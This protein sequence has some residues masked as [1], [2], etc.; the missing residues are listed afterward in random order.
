[1]PPIRPTRRQRDRAPRVNRTR[2][3]SVRSK[4]TPRTVPNTAEGAGAK[5]QA[6]A[7]GL[8]SFF[9]PLQTFGQAQQRQALDAIEQENRKLAIEA[10]NQALRNPQKAAEAIRQG[11]LDQFAPNA[12]ALT[13]RAFV[14]TFKIS[15][16]KALANET[17][18][19]EW[20]DRLR[21]L[22]F[23]TGDPRETRNEILDEALDEKS[24]PIF[25]AQFR[26]TFQ[27]T[28]EK[29]IQNWR[30]S[31]AAFQQAQALDRRLDVMRQE[32]QRGKQFTSRAF[33]DLIADSMNSATTAENK[34][35]NRK[36][37][38]YQIMFNSLKS[39]NNS[40][41][42]AIH[43][44]DP[45]HDGLSLADRF[46]EEFK[47]AQKTAISDIGQVRSVEQQR[48]Y[49]EIEDKLRQIETNGVATVQTEDGPVEM[50]IN[51]VTRELYRSR[52]KYGWSN[53]WS[54]LADEAASLYGATATARDLAQKAQDCVATGTCPY[55]DPT[56]MNDHGSAIVD[57]VT[58]DKEPT[59]AAAAVA[60]LATRYGGLGNDVNRRFSH[61][62][63]NTGDPEK[64]TGTFRQLEAIVAADNGKLDTVEGMLKSD[65]AKNKFRFLHHMTNARGMNP[66]DAAL[67]YEE[68]EEAVIKPENLGTYV[69]KREDQQSLISDTVARL[70]DLNPE[71]DVGS[72]SDTPATG[73]VQGMVERE[74]S[75]TFALMQAHNSSISAED[76]S[77]MTAAAVAGQLSLGMNAQGEKV[78]TATR[79]PR[80]L[81]DPSTGK[82]RPTKPMTADRLDLAEE[83]WAETPLADRAGNFAGVMPDPIGTPRGYG[84]QVMMEDPATG[85]SNPII[86]EKG[87]TYEVEDEAEEAA[88]TGGRQFPQAAEPEGFRV[89]RSGEGGTTVTIPE[90]MSEYPE[91]YAIDPEGHFRLYQHP[92]RPNAVKMYWAPE[93]QPSPEEVRAKQAK[94][95]EQQINELKAK[96]KFKGQLDEEARALVERGVADMPMTEDEAEAI[97]SL[98]DENPDTG[99]TVPGT[100]FLFEEGPEGDLRLDSRI[101]SWLGLDGPGRKT[102]TVDGEQ[103]ETSDAMTDRA[104]EELQSPDHDLANDM[105]LEYANEPVM[106]LRGLPPLDGEREVGSR[107]T[108]TPLQGTVD[109][110]LNYRAPLPSQKPPVPTSPPSDE[111]KREFQGMVDHMTSMKMTPPETLDSM[112]DF[113]EP[114]SEEELVSAI[115]TYLDTASEKGALG[116]DVSTPPNETLMA[117][118][119]QFIGVSEGAELRAYK[120]HNGH[121]TVGYGFNLDRQ[122]ARQRIEALGFDYDKVRSGEQEITEAAAET[123][124]DSALAES[125]DVVKRKF[126]DTPMARHQVAALASLH[127]NNPS[128][129]GPRLT[130]WIKQGEWEKA[131]DEIELLSNKNEVYGI[132]LRRQREAAMFR[133]NFHEGSGSRIDR[134]AG[135]H[136]VTPTPRE[137]PSRVRALK[138]EL[139]NTFK[140]S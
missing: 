27:E 96:E 33:T 32:M 108:A 104:D 4:V 50:G 124:R 115:T 131:A 139:I 122:D 132:K 99:R 100:M 61:D 30:G 48:S 127:Y 111:Y 28:T 121:P 9:K 60:T 98:A 86:L 34:I 66:Q 113:Q 72:F 95:L 120:D 39:G 85:V 103:V 109:R 110:T 77:Q 62:L 56:T 105:A 135:M 91:G 123:L 58:A 90:D 14:E 118:L 40:A 137:Q 25:Q 59:E 1:M 126:S 83:Q 37:A 92:T 106:T 13:R 23:K 88:D 78:I 36:A 101:R 73:T 97:Q 84:Y 138:Q 64:M 52:Q 128:L 55:I 65:E 57:A 10:E 74:L 21:R 2:G 94:R 12:D 81:V 82:V 46:P 24:D 3:A 42:E 54:S 47:R 117:E 45:D 19:T 140:G 5:G 87:T 112:P 136:G 70:D 80:Q 11:T 17:Y 67:L 116:D 69:P 75:R 79:P 129:I 31:Q 29:D 89:I 16:G 51:D 8:S 53:K 6:L 130:K 125:V 114:K 22:D 133:G 15:T 68:S 20:Q 119:R 107:P 71:L 63:M 49:I 41:V 44:P 93:F 102:V 38:A 7:E 76:V 35:K 26:K 18:A 43:Q 134:L